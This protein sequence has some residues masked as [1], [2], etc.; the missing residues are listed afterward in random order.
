MT[1]KKGDS[2]YQNRDTNF[3][4]IDRMQNEGLAG[5]TV[6][7]QNGLIVESTTDTMDGTDNMD[8]DVQKLRERD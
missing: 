6:S 8:D 1:D 7:D 3:I 2:L 5:G 4:D